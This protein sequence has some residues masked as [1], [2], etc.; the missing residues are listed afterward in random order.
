[1]SAQQSIMISAQLNFSSHTLRSLIL[2][3]LFLALHARVDA[4]VEDINTLQ[5]KL[6][7][8]VRET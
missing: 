1:M 5:L 4:E 2:F 8:V 3:L 6:T 7:Q